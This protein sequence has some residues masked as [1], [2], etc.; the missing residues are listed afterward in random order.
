MWLMIQFAII[1]AIIAAFLMVRTKTRRRRN[2]LGQNR[3]AKRF[4]RCTALRTRRRLALSPNLQPP[5]DFFM[6]A[7]FEG[8]N[9]FVQLRKESF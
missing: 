2:L 6:K 4:L 5:K 7:P 9:R 3:I 1:V 8:Y